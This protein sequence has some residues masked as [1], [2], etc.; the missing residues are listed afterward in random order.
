MK[1]TDANLAEALQLSVNKYMAYRLKARNATDKQRLASEYVAFLNDTYV[2]SEEHKTER[3][4]QLLKAIIQK[5]Q[6]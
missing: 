1:V 4:A 3:T 2:N 5:C 6:Y